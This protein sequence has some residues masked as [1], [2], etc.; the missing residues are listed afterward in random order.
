MLSRRQVLRFGAGGLAGLAAPGLGPTARAQS[1]DF[2]RIGTG[3]TSGTLYGLGTAIAA[4]ISRPP[5]AAPCD[6]SGICGVP[7]LVA[8]AQS[9][10]DSRANLRAL[11]AGQADSALVHADMAYWAYTGQGPMA[12]DGPDR[13]LRMLANLI[14][15]QIHIV[16]RTDSGIASVEDLKARRVSVGP[17]GSGT[18][19][20]AAYVLRGHGVAM[21]DID[22]RDLKPGPAADALRRGDIDAILLAGAAP[23]PAIQDLARTTEIRLI[24]IRDKEIGML[25]GLY[26]FFAR[27]RIPEGAYRGT[28]AAQTVS[29]GVYWVVR[30]GLDPQLAEDITRALWQGQSAAVFAADNPGTPFADRASAAIVRGVPLHA[31]AEAY[32]AGGTA[33]AGG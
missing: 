14:P 8:V 5:G 15:V 29:I 28:G 32:Y 22:A 12:E 23:V 2:F 11:R 31:G 25:T 19:S 16:T 27:A 1:V 20:N 7:G 26:P 6:A 13:D 3:P 24:S 17:A 30:A 21:E 9:R 33:Q 18:G 10:S 4:G